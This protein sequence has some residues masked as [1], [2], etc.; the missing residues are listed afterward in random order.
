[1]T[2]LKTCSSCS[3]QSTKKWYTGPLCGGCYRKKRSLVYK[4]PRSPYDALIAT[5][6]VCTKTKKGG[7]RYFKHTTCRSCYSQVWRKQN[8]DSPR[9]S[10]KKRYTKEKSAQW[11]A[12]NP[13]RY[14]ELRQRHYKKNKGNFLARNR[15]KKAFVKQQTPSWADKKAINKIYNNTPPGHHVDHIIPL[16]GKNVWGFHVEYNLQYLPA[17]ENLKKNNKCPV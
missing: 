16:R 8:P 14:K 6:A 12:K 7:N 11:R 1:M 9:A 13:K 5:C 2:C 15:A 10:D 3:T 4:F 17:L